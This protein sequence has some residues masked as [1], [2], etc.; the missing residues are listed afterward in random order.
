MIAAYYLWV[1]ALGWIPDSVWAAVAADDGDPLLPSVALSLWGVFCIG[2]AAL[3]LG[4]LGAATGV[5]HLRR[6]LGLP[7]TIR[8]CLGIALA[9]GGRIWA[10]QWWD[11]WLTTSQIAARIPSKRNRNS[12]AQEGIYYAWKLG[13]AGVLPALTLGGGLVD[14]GRRSI[15]FVADNVASVATLRVGY[16]V[17]CWFV[18]IGAW[19]SALM[20]AN[21][22]LPP[23]PAE[24]VAHDIRRFY[25][26]VGV[27][28]ASGAGVVLLLLRPIY[29]ITIADL[30]ADHLEAS[31]ERVALPRGLTTL[32]WVAVLYAVFAWALLFAVVFRDVLGLSRLFQ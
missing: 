24:P 2:L 6:R 26:V 4:V 27:S 23:G 29:L 30:F 19:V 7:S 15:K 21:A 25:Q 1:A 10:F 17:V 28:V 8:D 11:G 18:G 32:S 5:V 9:N 22:F 16:S 31:G 20:L 14:A 3:P 12:L 13:T